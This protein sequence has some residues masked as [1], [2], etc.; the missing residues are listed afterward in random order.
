MW[1]AA[2]VWG[3][4]SVSSVARE[5]VSVQHG[6]PFLYVPAP[7]AFCPLTGEGRLRCLCAWK[8]ISKA[9]L[10][11]PWKNLCGHKFS[12]HVCKL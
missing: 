8:I 2:R 7:A 5:V 9:A 4:A 6:A 11:I 10:S 3:A 12:T 1:G